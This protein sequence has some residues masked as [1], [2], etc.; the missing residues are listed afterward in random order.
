MKL[1]VK[2]LATTTLSA[3]S[4]AS[5]AA[6]AQTAPAPA[7]PP[8]ADSANQAPDIVVVG[9]QIRGSKV[10]E[11]LPVSVVDS[12]QIAATGAVSGDEL[13][14]SIPQMG[15]VDFNS[16]NNPQTSNA[17]RGDVN[18]VDLRNLGAGNT[19]VLINGRR[20]VQHP[21]SQAGIANV[22]VLTY[23]ANALPVAGIDR[24]EVLRDGAAAIYGADAVAGVV[25]VV[26]KDDFE[27]L[28][29]NAKYG[30]A[31]GTHM[32]EY[33]TNFLAGKN[34]GDGRGNITL[35]GEFTH[36]TPELASDEPYTATGNLQSLFDDVPGYADSTEPEN[37][38][39]YT[40]FANFSVL[41]GMAVK[42]NG[43]T[44]TSGAGA[45]HIQ[46]D[47]VDGCTAALGHGMCLA[48]GSISYGKNPDLRFDDAVGTTVR[49][50]IN[51]LNLYA[52][53]H[54]DVTDHVTFFT[55]LGYYHATS[56]AVQPPVILL[57]TLTVPASNYWNPFGAETLP[58]GS[59][60]PNRLSGLTNVPAEVLPVTLTRYRF[61]DTGPQYVDVTGHQSRFVGGFRGDLAGFDWEAAATYSEAKSV[62]LSDAINS[63]LLQQQ[64][65][66]STPDAYD[67]FNGGGCGTNYSVGDCTPSS[68]AAVKPALF[69]L[70]RE[71]RT[72]LTL[73]DLKAS[74]ADLLA[75]PGGD[76]GLAVGIEFRHETQEDNRDPNLDG[77][78]NFVDSVTGETNPSNVTAV[79]PTPDTFGSRNVFSA[80]GEFAVPVIAPE[81]HVPLVRN[82]QF[83]IAGRYEH[84]SDFGSIFRPKFAGAW[85]VIDG[86]RLRGSWSQGFRAPNLEQLH[87][88]EYARLHTNNDYLR[89][90][91]DLRAGRIANFNACS[92]PVGYSI[93]VAGNPDLQPERSTDKSVGIVLQPRF[94][95]RRLGHVTITA[96][97]W[98]IKQKGIVGQFGGSN[99]LVLDYLLRQQGSS[100]PNVVRTAP[101]ADDVAFFAGTGI[102]PVGQVTAVNDQFVNLLPQTVR[103]LDLAFLYSLH[104]TSIGD[105]DFSVNA[106]RLLKFSRSNGPAVEQLY[107][108]RRAGEIDAATPLT[109]AEN[110]LGNGGRPK[111]KLSTSLTWSLGA[112]QVG[113]FGKYTGVVYDH[114][115]LSDDG[116]PY[117]VDGQF[118]ANLYVQY[119]FA[120]SGPL[121]GSRFRIGARNI[122]NEQPPISAGGYYGALYQPYGRY[123]Y[124]SFGFSL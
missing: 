3:L 107:E 20:M 99:A 75:L 29:L 52:S 82:L 18:S 79:S 16:A 103:G 77:T 95:P 12:N 33:T 92:E 46:P 83:Q 80:Y 86:V 108:A 34:F 67:P 71:D 100:N 64:L 25:N 96:D 106:A 44:I 110:L 124:A 76:L 35:M 10:T 66:L 27:G 62:D 13:L 1:K 45:F 14:R 121:H 60:N 84:Y 88:A 94:I 118:T 69:K 91:A 61:V 90:E 23:N 11:A 120:R 42:R 26:L 98:E 40:P 8:A 70:R 24:L 32:R 48:K 113:A 5:S 101:N 30:G 7:S 93:R 19:L 102:D 9:S 31:E 104:H 115:F 74:R 114:G 39:S 22:P 109:S 56:H 97:Y 28:K 43:K 87:A 63:T 57:N 53:G 122:T 17:A 116:D 21:V 2:I 37:R 112:V 47:T 41:D 123:L 72:T 36:R 55:E 58:D 111:W 54:Y 65:A 119:R 73:A 49:S 59:P 50:G 38:S 89:C 117:R 81:M 4:I 68:A 6:H 85:D 51:R 105:F 15:D 78:I